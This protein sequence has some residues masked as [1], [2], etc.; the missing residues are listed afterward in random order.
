M[1]TAK[2]DNTYMELVREFPLVPLRR[3]AQFEKAIAVMK[4]LVYRRSSLT[5]GEADY[6]AVL[7][8]LIIQYEKRLPR[9]TPEISP[10][11]TLR[12]LMDANGLTQSDL[13]EFVGHKSNLSAF[14]NGHRGLSKRA[15]CR[16]GERFKVSPSLFLPKE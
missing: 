10:R 4:S 11:E 13:V 6:L 2:V 15:A 14:L 8:D 12:Y 16:L 5:Q 9:I 3:K 1:N 7:G